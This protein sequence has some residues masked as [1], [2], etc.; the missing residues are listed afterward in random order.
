M[1]IRAAAAIA[2]LLF[3]GCPFPTKNWGRLR[4]PEMV[5]Q[6]S[7]VAADLRAVMALRRPGHERAVQVVVL[8]V[9][10]GRDGPDRAFPRQPAGT[11]TPVGVRDTCGS[12]EARHRRQVG[13]ARDCKSRIRR[14]ESGR[15]LHPPCRCRLGAWPLCRYPHNSHYAE[16]RIMPSTGGAD[17]VSPRAQ[18]ARGSG[19][20]GMIR[21]PLRGPAVR[22]SWPR[23]SMRAPP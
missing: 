2:G 7:G 4:R 23:T 11:L 19:G 6:R 3:A 9:R 12:L 5:E 1:R 13:K 17:L 14:F 22:P 15:C 8:R 20:L 16:S 21:G 10:G 18:G